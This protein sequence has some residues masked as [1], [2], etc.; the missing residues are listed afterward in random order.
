M[1]A[2]ALGFGEPFALS[3]EHGEGMVDLF[4][5]L[6]PHLEPELAEG[7]VAPAKEPRGDDE[8]MSGRS[9]WRSSGGPMRASRPWSTRCS[10]RTG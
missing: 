9:S 3:A 4:E 8:D 2:F 1:E 6:R 10:T 5:A 7:E